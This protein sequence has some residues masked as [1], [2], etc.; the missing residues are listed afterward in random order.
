[1]LYQFSADQGYQGLTICFTGLSGAGKTTLCNSVYA[2]LIA[3]GYRTEILD[4]DVIRKQVWPD[5]GFSKED[6]AENI[7]RIATL[8]QSLNR[9][10][11]IAL[12]AAISPYRA[13]RNE[14]RQKIAHFLEIYVDAPMHI[15]EERDPKGLYKKARSGELPNFTGI[16]DPYEPPLAPEVQCRTDRDTVKAC[17]DQVVVAVLRYC[18]NLLAASGRKA[19]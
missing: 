16:D 7:R 13:V 12:V 6:R 2:E 1:M 9:N 4:A 11:I 5:L 17:T 3:R 18:R 15:C 10:Q 19:I 8:A 14:V